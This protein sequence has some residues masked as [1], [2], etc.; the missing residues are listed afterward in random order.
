[1]IGKSQD[2]V[3]RCFPLAIFTAVPLA[4]AMRHLPVLPVAYDGFFRAADA[5]LAQAPQ[6][7]LEAVREAVIAL[8]STTTGVTRAAQAETAEQ[9]QHAAR[10][11]LGALFSADPTDAL[12]YA[13]HTFCAATAPVR[14]AP[15]LSAGT[16][17]DCPIGVEAALAAW[18]DLV[19]RRLA[20]RQFCPTLL[21]YEADSDPRLL[22][23][24]GAASDQ[25]L[26]FVVDPHSR[27]TRLWPLRSQR[28]EAIERARSGLSQVAAA[29]SADKALTIAEL[30]S[31]VT[32]VTV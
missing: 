22:L 5:L 15:P 4:E 32:H 12:F 11:V 24:L 28:S 7:S 25:L 3:G 17:L 21:W 18:L 14:A 9:L 30:W 8:G 2:Q 13:L 6:L 19:Q 20:W 26:S 10:H 23:A 27:S 31:L 1:V 29:L 16:V